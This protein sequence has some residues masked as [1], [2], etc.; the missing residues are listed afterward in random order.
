MN[1]DTLLPKAEIPFAKAFKFNNSAVF[2][3]R[4]DESNGYYWKFG[5]AGM[6][7]YFAQVCFR[8]NS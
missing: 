1:F 7:D 6:F 8:V 4:A 5:F 3:N 2:A